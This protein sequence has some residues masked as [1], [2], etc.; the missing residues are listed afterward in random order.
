[1]KRT[2]AAHRAELHLTE[3]LQYQTC[4]AREVTK[5]N[6]RR[7]AFRFTVPRPKSGANLLLPCQREV[8]GCVLEEWKSGKGQ[9][10]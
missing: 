5:Q 9:L 3:Q 4:T 1:M 7:V 2:L 8:E 10:R 6:I